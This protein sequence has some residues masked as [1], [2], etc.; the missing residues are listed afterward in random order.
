MN[1]D[2]VHHYLGHLPI[3]LD[4]IYKEIWS[5]AIGNGDDRRSHR[6]KTILLWVSLA[7]QLLSTTALAEAVAAS[8]GSQPGATL[9]SEHEIASLCAGLIRFETLLT[10][11]DARTGH[12]GIESVATLSHSS[13]QQ[14]LD[15]NRE[16]YFPAAHDHVVNACL[17]RSGRSDLYDALSFLSN[18]IVYV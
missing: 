12:R 7:E 13:V 17:S 9:M 2:D 5:R 11:L 3:G 14:F 1:A 18:S 10:G 4:A 16:E 6:V 15:K 8:E